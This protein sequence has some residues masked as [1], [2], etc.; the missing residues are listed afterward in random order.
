MLTLCQIEVAR[1][2]VI[3]G[4]LVGAAKL[5]NV[6]AP[7]I[8]RLM[9]YTEQ[10]LGMRLFDKRGGRLV[11]SEPARDIFEQI[12]V[13]FRNI[14]DLRYVID[15]V[16]SGAA[17]EFRIGS[18]PSISQVMVPRAIERLRA[19]FP[20]LL[21]DINMLK[22]EEAVDYLLLGKG[23]VVAMSSR[24]E[25]PGLTFEPLAQG[26]FVCIVPEGHALAQSSVVSAAEI[27]R[28]PLIGIERT[29]PYGRMI[30]DIFS[31]HDLDYTPKIRARFGTTV[32]S[33]VKS[34]LGIA[35]IDQFTVAADAVPGIRLI[36]IEGRPMIQ[37]WI[38]TKA[39]A[40]KS[41]FATNFI[42]NLR[43]EMTAQVAA[44]D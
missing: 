31:R 38:I 6:S 42:H 15:R 21:I 22:I 1:A 5:L 32:S 25:H 28:H 36:A 16:K 43:Q 14:E 39:G 17:Q 18:A 40:A 19:Q 4:S 29:D 44:Q 37:T 30:A 9:K 35:V 26:H 41:T 13:V 23:E 12:N 34:G 20:D 3:T 10:T 2:V 11:P 27:A 8:S 7:G 33:L 24:F